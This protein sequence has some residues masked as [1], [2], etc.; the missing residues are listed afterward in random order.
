MEKTLK[1]A[2]IGYGKMGQEIEKLA[3]KEGYRVEVIIDQPDHWQKYH[4]QLKEMDVAVEF[5]TPQAVAG[6]LKKLM[7]MGVPVVTGT[8]GWMD[9]LQEISTYCTKSNGSVF[10]ASNFS[11]GVNLFFAINRYL[12]RI[13]S[14]YPEYKPTLEE[15]HH[16]RKLDAPS[17]TALT[18][19]REIIEQ[20]PGLKGWKFADEHPSENEVEVT[21]HRIDDVTGTHTMSYSSDIDLIRIQHIAHNRKGFARGALLAARWL[22]NKKGIFTM[23]DLLKL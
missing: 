19:I 16:T 9:Q 6:N 12:A 13:M 14:D 17:G 8:T 18:M 2:I 23:N 3:P 4:D 7:D 11:I 21:A 15:I 22:H 5:T 1:L 10:Y 20:N